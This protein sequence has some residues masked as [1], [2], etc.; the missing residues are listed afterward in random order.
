MTLTTGV[1]LC[2]MHCHLDFANNAQELAS[3]LRQCGVGCFSTTVEPCGYEYAIDV[4]EPFDNVRVGLGLH[5]WWVADGRC[6]EEALERFESLVVDAA[7]IGEVGLDFGTAH[8]G[9]RVVQL[10][11]FNRVAAACAASGGKVLSIHAVGAAEEVLNVLEQQGCFDANACIFHWFSGSSDE[12]QRAIK[13]GCFFSVGERMLATARGRAYARTIPKTQL[14]LETD[15]PSAR[16][17]AL[18]S[19]TIEASL[20]RT[21]VSLESV[22]SESLV[23]LLASTSAILLRLPR[24]T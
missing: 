4:L 10:A 9:S 3:D 15:L 18:S 20:S 16:V 14:L 6:G 22:R 11:A 17:D 2:D 8:R 7:F 13:H 23:E 24:M 19:S 12:L 1:H 5:P 21:L